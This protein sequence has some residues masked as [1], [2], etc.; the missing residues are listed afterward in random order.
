MVKKYARLILFIALVTLAVLYAREI[1]VILRYV[2]AALEPVLIA[3]FLALIF[4][5]PIKFLTNKVFAKM[6]RRKLAYILS[7]VIVYVL[8]FGILALGIYFLAPE[9]GKSLGGFVNKLPEYG[10][11]LK[12]KLTEILQK[13]GMSS[14]K[15]D[16]VFTEIQNAILG[17]NDKIGGVVT[18]VKQFGRGF[19][20]V[21][22][23]IVLS[24]YIL[25]D[26]NRLLSQL[27]RFNKAIFPVKVSKTLENTASVGGVIFAKF[28]GGQV[29]EATLLAVV[30][31][32]GM[33]ALKLPYPFLISAVCFAANLVPLLGAYIGGIIGF[34][35]I[36]FVSVKQAV[37]FVIFT[38]IL[39]QLENSI[40]YP[41]IVG[42]SLGLSGFWV[43]S[44][45]LVGGALFGFWG[46]MLGV[47]A[48]AVLYKMIG[49]KLKDG[50]S[51]AFLPEIL[52]ESTKQGGDDGTQ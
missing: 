1:W 37:I 31:F 10:V 22:F 11:E 36:A 35:L 20:N 4:N 42:N 12:Q 50:E 52:K 27:K 19:I 40:T 5:I 17:A 24:V 3:V 18:R 41:K 47:P 39:Q 21:L 46:I 23:A 2:F 6:K 9:V 13:F 48:V 26:K 43:M 8:V 33:L 44:S 32:F 49:Y 29:I 38:V 30:T 51:E 14:E 34:V 28:L 15:T 25:L 7:L 45:V 16:A